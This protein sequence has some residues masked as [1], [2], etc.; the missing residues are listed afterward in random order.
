MMLR[1]L[2]HLKENDLEPLIGYLSQVTGKR[3]EVSKDLW[4][5]YLRPWKLFSLAVGV[6]L[7]IAGSYHY[8][9]PDWDIPV[10]LIMA[11]FAYLTAPWSMRVIVKLQWRCFPQML[12]FTWLTVDGV[13]ALYWHFQ[14]PQALAAMRAANFPASLSLYWM[15]GLIW[16]Y[17]G[18]L[19]ELWN[20]AVNTFSRRGL[21]S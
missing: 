20:D 11:F 18:T 12:F 19:K 4:I 2:S 3:M 10:S 1:Y 15:C 9:A 21:R 6:A 8:A 17:R 16:Y 5:E 13:Y 7:L 14:D